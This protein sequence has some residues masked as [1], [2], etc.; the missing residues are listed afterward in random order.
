MSEAER[1][2]AYR[3]RKTARAKREAARRA[4]EKADRELADRTGGTYVVHH[5]GIDDVPAEML[6]DNSV[7]A[8]VTDPPFP[9]KFLPL[10]SSLSRFAARVLKPGRL[11]PR[12]DGQHLPAGGRQ[13]S[14]QA[15]HIQMA[16]RHHDAGRAQQQGGPCWDVPGLQADLDLSEAAGWP[17][18]RVVVRR[19]NG[20]DR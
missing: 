6:A 11:V 4:R 1:A 5:V 7:D 8:I 18:S 3:R 2:K 20:R 19:G 9:E 12:H 15:P 13:P 17:G 14:Q 16:V 10:F